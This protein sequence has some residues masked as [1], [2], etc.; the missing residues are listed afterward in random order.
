MI[1]ESNYQHIIQKGH[2]DVS[3]VINDAWHEGYRAGTANGK[4][5]VLGFLR[6][7][8]ASAETLKAWLEKGEQ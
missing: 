7:T 6:R 3:S 5:E 4:R 1:K 2:S 8:G